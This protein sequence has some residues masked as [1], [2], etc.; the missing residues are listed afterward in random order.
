MKHFLILLV[1]TTIMAIILDKASA[2]IGPLFDLAVRM[3]R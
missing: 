1:I 2:V 3:A